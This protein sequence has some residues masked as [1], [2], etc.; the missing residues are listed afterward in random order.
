MSSA[1]DEAAAGQLAASVRALHH[2]QIR[3]AQSALRSN[4]HISDEAIHAARKDIKRARAS[5]RLLRPVIGERCYRSQN[6]RLRDAGRPLSRIRDARALL[7][8]AMDEWHRAGNKRGPLLGDLVAVLRTERAKVRKDAS[9]ASAHIHKSLGKLAIAE[10]SSAHWTLDR[11]AR[12]LP[13]SLRRLY[14]RGRKS[15]AEA[16]ASTSDETFHE[17]RKQAKYLALALETLQAVH[18][19][20]ARRAIKRGKHIGDELGL[21]HDLALL[22]A[23]LAD[24]SSKSTR[25]G[26]SVGRR[27]DKRRRRLQRKAL[28]AGHRLYAS[29]PRKFVRRVLSQGPVARDAVT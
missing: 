7:D 29:K 4:G 2:D 24:L 21:D 6:A 22:R 28:H 19:G 20:G 12:A 1:M 3:H 14:R 5:L 18:P 8:T 10:R 13:A 11:P 27:M 17:A 15:L 23:K 26:D 16:S 25:G 9:A